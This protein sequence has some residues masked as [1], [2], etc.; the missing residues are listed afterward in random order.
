MR[1]PTIKATMERRILVNYRVRPEALTAI[2]P[3]PPT[4]RRERLRHGRPGDH[5][6]APA[7]APRLDHRKGVEM[8]SSP[9]SPAS[10]TDRRSV[11]RS[12]Y[13]RVYLRCLGWGIATGAATGAVVGFIY[14]LGAGGASWLGLSMVGA[15]YGIVLGALISVLPSVLGAAVVTGVI[16]W[17]HPSSPGAV[18][19]DLG[20]IFAV[21]VGVLD[22]GLLLAIAFG[23]NGLSSV[24]SSLPLIVPG[25]VSVA[26]ML[27][28]AR[29]SIGR[30]WL[31]GL[32]NGTAYYIKDRRG[33]DG[34]RGGERGGDGV[35]LGSYR[36]T[37]KGLSR[38]I[39][40]GHGYD[41]QRGARSPR[42]R[43]CTSR[44]CS[45][46]RVHETHQRR[47]R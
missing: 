40:S 6:A 1:A 15:L 17:R 23:G 16:A 19:R 18:Q 24:T 41:G 37:R 20:L 2:L 45:R 25:N 11:G 26:L 4:R 27:W 43:P 38:F 36:R 33:R 34:E 30:G 9:G 32:E 47:P 12:P 21:L 31:A 42:A 5:V 13:V 10:S 35:G 22:A 28:W 29:A 46:R 8:I 39:G 14:G 44:L 7:E 3:S